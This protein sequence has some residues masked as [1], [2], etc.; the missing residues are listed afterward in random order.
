MS[1]AETLHVVSCFLRLLP[2]SLLRMRYSA[3]L[4]GTGAVMT[5]P[6]LQGDPT[7]RAAPTLPTTVREQEVNY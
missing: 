5:A 3:V 2:L 4:R 6:H 7:E 1:G